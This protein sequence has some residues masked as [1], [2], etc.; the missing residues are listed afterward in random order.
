MV[1]EPDG[2]A[3]QLHAPLSTGLL[4]HHLEDPPTGQLANTV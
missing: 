2:C 4:I 1:V 3:G